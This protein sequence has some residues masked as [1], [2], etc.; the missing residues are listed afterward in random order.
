MDNSGHILQPNEFVL[1]CTDEWVAINSR[2]AAKLEGKSSLAR[3]GIIVQTAGF[4]DPGWQG[5]LTLEVKNLSERIFSL[6]QGMKIIQIRFESLLTPSTR[7]YG[8]EGL[9]SHYQGSEG[10]VVARGEIAQY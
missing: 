10:T 5:Q 7:P 2:I 6:E 4:V 3:R 9:N 1:C 8:S